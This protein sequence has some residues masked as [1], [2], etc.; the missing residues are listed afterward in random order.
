MG[1][2][3]AR[4]KQEENIQQQTAAVKIHAPVSANYFTNVQA[5]LVFLFAFLL[6]ANTISHDY[7]VDDMIVVQKNK[8]TNKGFEGIGEIMT[9]D[10]FYGFFGEDY[11]FVAGGRY[12]P[13]SIVTFAVEV[14]FFGQ[15]PH[16]SHF[17]NAVLYGITCVLIFFLLLHLFRTQIN[18]L[19]QL[20]IPLIATLLYAG[21]PIHTEVVANIKGR[22]E[23]LGLLFSVLTLLLSVKYID[24]KN[25]VLLLLTFVSFI[26]ALLSKENAITFLAVVPLTLYFFTHA[27]VKDYVTIT[28]PMVIIAGI[29][30]MLRQKFTD[31]DV[32]A[33]TKEILNNPF[34]FA[35]TGER[36][37]TVAFTFWEYIRLLFIPHPLTHDYYFNQ[38]PII[39]WDNVKAILPFLL[40]LGI[41][42]WALTK[43]KSKNIFSFGILYYFVTISI[44]SNVLFTVGIA[45]NERFVFIPSLGF[46]IILAALLVKAVN[47]FKEKNFASLE[48]LS[49]QPT[50]MVLA[51]ILIGYSAKTFTRN[52]DW[53]ND[54]T[55][56]AADFKNSPNSAKIRNSYGGE[57]VTRADKV[58][59]PT[60]TEYLKK[61]EI[62]L[63]EALKIYPNY[64]N[65]L[66]LMGNA[67]YKLYD[68]LPEARYYYEQTIKQ[69]P[70][71]YEGNFNLG[72]ILLAKKYYAEAIPY[73]KK[74]LIKGGDKYE[75]W[76][77]LGDAYMNTNNPD[78]AIYYYQS[79]LKLKPDLAV[80]YYKI[81]LCYAKMKNDFS[82][83]FANFEKA[84]QLD[85]SNYTFYEDL[86][87]AH[88][89]NKEYQKAIEAFERGIKVKPDY[90][91]FYNNIGIT[92]KQL[93]DEAKANE[94]FA[95]AQQV[96]GQQKK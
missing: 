20:S 77:Y 83:G 5:L 9:T 40:N 82:N 68:S 71:Y 8:L 76:F 3:A 18:G 90:P 93:G 12:R 45:M 52:L 25:A 33:D 62:V 86:G 16:I 51:L 79:T 69:R 27:K 30:V 78:S 96:A 94:Y 70:D 57:L 63:G 74:S 38:V 41:L 39:G 36:L 73:L 92:Y 64:Q 1:K 49:P 35:T 22:D 47:Y 28:V 7:A 88:G 91:S 14:E 43:I 34:V 15:N 6:Y 65:A 26:L 95:K 60:R 42:I 17:I 89:I 75:P 53:E 66:L 19:W 31:V 58:A 23:I 81:G 67:K 46:C 29:Y 80:A 59:E 50:A 87:V 56:F 2:K 54:F 55:L 72:T 21:H 4:R 13:L 24:R 48:V 61:A 10:A 44:V 84:I 32:M 11:K 37:A 85:P